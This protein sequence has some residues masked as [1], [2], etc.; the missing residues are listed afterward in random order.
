M[1]TYIALFRAINVG[2]KNILTM[3][4]LIAI[5]ENLGALK[6]KTY[7]QSGNALFQTSETDIAEFKS[8]LI[9]QIKLQHG[10]EPQIMV[11][12]REAIEK[13][14]LENPYPE[15]E[16][17]PVIPPFLSSLKSRGQACNASFCFGVMPPNPMCGR[18]LL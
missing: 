7:I 12:D 9:S 1:K 8:K 10:F 15:A 17:D 2:G 16:T 5:L 4:A 13:A 18:S 11:I 14:I 3:K 6:V